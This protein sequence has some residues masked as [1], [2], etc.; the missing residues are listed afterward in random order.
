MICGIMVSTSLIHPGG[1]DYSP[2]SG[3]SLTFPSGSVTNGALSFNVSI[4]DD[5]ILEF[6]EFFTILAAS[7]DSAVTFAPWRDTS[8][9]NILD[10]DSVSVEIDLD[11]YSI[12]EG[13]GL[14]EVCLVVIGDLA[15]DVPIN[16]NSL[17]ITAQGMNIA[18]LV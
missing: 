2:L 10:D 4:T 17:D 13:D 11:N 3:F 6:D 12:R 5:S 16:I 18:Y 15:R 8:A 1:Q 14:L 9:V 7:M